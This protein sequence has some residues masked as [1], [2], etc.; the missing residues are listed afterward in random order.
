MA[1]RSPWPDRP[2]IY[3]TNIDTTKYASLDSQKKEA[4]HKAKISDW[5]IYD[6]AESEANS[7]IV[8]VV[9]DVWISPLSKGGPTLYAKRKTED[10]LDQLQVVCTGHHTINLLDLQD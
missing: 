2:G 3:A 6:V 5:E 1:N 7:F 9:A 8:R 4:V 10:L